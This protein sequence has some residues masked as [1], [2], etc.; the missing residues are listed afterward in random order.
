MAPVLGVAFDGG[1][2]LVALRVLLQQFGAQ[3]F[4]RGLRLMQAL[5]EQVVAAAGLGQP[6]GTALALC[7]AF[8]RLQVGAARGGLGFEQLGAGA[9]GIQGALDRRQGLLGLRRAGFGIAQRLA[10]GRRIDVVRLCRR[11]QQRQPFGQLRAPRL[12]FVALAAQRVHAL[13]R[14]DR[15]RLAHGIQ[16]AL[17]GDA[18]RVAFLGLGR[19]GH[20]QARQQG[21]AGR[22]HLRQ[23]ALERRQVL[24]ARFD[25]QT[26]QAGQ[27]QFGRGT[28]QQLAVAGQRG[29]VQ[30][31]LAARV[32]R[33][34]QARGDGL[35]AQLQ[36]AQRA[37]ALAQ[38]LD[39][40]VGDFDAHRFGLQCRA[41][42]DQ[43]GGFFQR[44]VQA[45]DVARQLVELLLQIAPVGHRLHRRDPLACLLGG[46]NV[47]IPEPPGAG[48][49]LLRLLDGGVGG[50]R[51]RHQCLQLGFVLLVAAH[52]LLQYREGLRRL[53]LLALQ[54]FEGFAFLGHGREPGA[55]L[56]R[57]RLEILPGLASLGARMFGAQRRQP[58]D[59]GVELGLGLGALIA[60]GLGGG[61]RVLGVLVDALGAAVARIQQAGALGG[62]AFVEPI[63]VAGSQLAGQLRQGLAQMA[64]GVA[65]GGLQVLAVALLDPQ[66]ARHAGQVGLALPARG[67]FEAQQCGQRVLGFLALQPLR[68]VV[69]QQLAAGARQEMLLQ[70]VIMAAMAERQLDAGTGA[71]L[72]ARRQVGHGAGAVAFQERGADGRGHG[73]LAGLVGTHEQVQ[74]ILQAIQHQGLAELAEFF[75]GDARELHC[76]P[77]A[78]AP[79]RWKRSSSRKASPAT[80]ACS[81]SAC[82]ACNCA[83]TSPT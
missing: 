25:A 68:A 8:G 82:M 7:R 28:Q 56:G 12:R 42:L 5:F 20:A 77:P 29:A 69:D 79:S 15:Q 75:Q 54:P 55:R 71:A 19:V 26:P 63:A 16:L 13:G 78:A 65:R 80:A 57:A 14:V 38:G 51:L 36:V 64:A 11:R 32:E 22:L 48:Q 2:F 66:Q 24:A 30:P 9:V 43:A 50:L 6:A 58:V 37:L 72:A 39:I 83:A 76:A 62:H 34:G 33:I 67:Q 59:V 52:L 70:L 41:L 3:R 81:G 40:G 18:A 1:G 44:A 46:G 21:G 23:F 45:F 53:A 60:L 27:L 47:R 74:A 31:G 10:R 35:L 4:Q 49:R 73:A 61:E 17:Q